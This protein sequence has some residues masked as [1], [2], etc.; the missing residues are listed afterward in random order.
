MTNVAIAFPRNPIHLAHQ[1]IDHQLLSEG[2]FALGLGTQIRTQIEKRFGAEFDK[3]VARMTELVAALRAIFARL[4]DRRAAGLPRRVLPP[5]ADDADVQ[6][7]RE[8]LR[9]AADLRRCARPS[10]DPRD[11][12]A[13]RRAAGHA[14]RQQAIP[15]RGDD[16][17]GARGAGGGGQGARRLR[18]HPGDHRVGRRGRRGSRR[19]PAAAGRSTARRPP[20][21]RCSR[22]T[23]GATCSPSSTR[24][25]SRAGGR[26][27]AR[28]S[29]TTCCTPSPRAA[30]RPR[31]RPISATGWTASPTRSACTSRAPSRRKRWPRSLTRSGLT[32]YRG[33]QADQGR[34]WP[35]ESDWTG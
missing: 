10:A 35:A 4:A 2:R 21:A 12:R 3:P 1:A 24:C 30:R 6:P 8:S 16:A 18:G 28:S 23:A 7:R 11:R 31:S 25:P 9:T 14:V 33:T 5:H 32:T 15:A 13:R 29:T 22:S 19:H 20:T 27:W 34:S 17:R 26:R